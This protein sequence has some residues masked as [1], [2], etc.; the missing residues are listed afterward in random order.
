VQIVCLDL[1][2][3]LIPEMWIAFSGRTGVP[4]LRRTACDERDFAGLT[5]R[6]DEAAGPIR[7]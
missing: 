2:G 7:G 5:A 4:E 3:V 1:E 6:I